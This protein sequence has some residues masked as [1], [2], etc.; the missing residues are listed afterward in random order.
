M[1]CSGSALFF[2]KQ[3]KPSSVDFC[4]TLYEYICVRSPAWT[5]ATL[6]N[7]DCLISTRNYT[8]DQSPFY[9]PLSHSGA[10]SD[11]FRKNICS[12][13]DLRS[14]IFE[15]FV[16]KFLPC[17]PLLGFSNIWKMVQL[18]IFNGIFTLK[19]S[20]RNFGNLFPGW[21]FWKGKFWSL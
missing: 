3:T 15:T 21:N 10:P 17:L 4:C 14:K 1:W 2:I 18:P 8:T 19:R 13:D 20:P 7:N 11:N 12:E 5:V 6:F 16:V 9:L